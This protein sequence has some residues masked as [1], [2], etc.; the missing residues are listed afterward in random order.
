MNNLVIADVP[1]SVADHY[2]ILRAMYLAHPQ[3]KC[4]LIPPKK[5]SLGIWDLAYIVPTPS[6]KQEKL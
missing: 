3:T 1:L 2:A 6:K 5:N 4:I